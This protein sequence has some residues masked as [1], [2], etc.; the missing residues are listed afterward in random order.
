MTSSKRIFITGASA[1]F[2]FDTAKALASAGHTV[3]ATMRDPSKKNAEKAEALR[4]FAK[5]T[6]GKIKVIELDVTNQDKVDKAVATAFAEGGVDVLINNAG[7]GTF[8]IDEGFTVEQAE[9]LLDT[10]LFGVM[11]VNRAVVPH[12]RKEGKGLIIYLSSGLGRLVLPFMAIYTA[13]KFAVEGYAESVS[14]ELSP[15]GIQT[16]IIQPGAFGTTFTPNCVT[17]KTDLSSV[18]GPSAQIFQA[19][20]KGFEER[21]KSGGIGDPKE[22]VQALVEEVER[23][24]GDRPLRRTVGRDVQEPVGAINQTCAQVQG[25]LFK[26]FGLQ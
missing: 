2:G 9:R 6:R 16:V 18:Y 11:R 23:P 17:P 26:A 25:H 24:A 12:F 8:G 7:V 22:V 1:G 4:S 19:F 20:G 13:S 21:I 5:D 14:I 15:L 3:F 10:N